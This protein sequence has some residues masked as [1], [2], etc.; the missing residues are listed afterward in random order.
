M[1][2]SKHYEMSKLHFEDLTRQVEFNSTSGWRPV[3]LP[4]FKEH[5]NYRFKPPHDIEGNKMFVGPW[6]VK[7]KTPFRIT[8]LDISATY[9]DY[10]FKSVTICY[11][12]GS[13]G[14]VYPWE[15]MGAHKVI[16]ESKHKEIMAWHYADPSLPIFYRAKNGLA[17]QVCGRPISFREDWEYK[18]GDPLDAHGNL[19]RVGECYTCNG[20][21]FILLDVDSRRAKVLNSDESLYDLPIIEIKGAVPCYENRVLSA[22]IKILF[23]SYYEKPTQ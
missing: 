8:R 16:I 5:E 12:N 17:W 18:L 15:I 2:K 7:D 10:N 19:F 13:S 1:S 6:Y 11:W 21:T 23:R 22:F 14:D 3:G 9:N 4:T 20:S